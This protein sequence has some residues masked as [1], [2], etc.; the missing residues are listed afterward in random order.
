MKVVHKLEPGFFGTG[1]QKI[2][3]V[4]PISDNVTLCGQ[5]WRYWGSVGKH[6]GGGELAEG[7]INLIDCKKCLK[8][9]NKEVLK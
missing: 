2:H 4:S 7:T 5:A 1:I 8:K 6:G 9:L 3:A